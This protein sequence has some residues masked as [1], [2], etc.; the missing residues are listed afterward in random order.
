M[1]K[2][3]ITLEFFLTFS[4]FLVLVILFSYSILS[5]KNTIDRSKDILQYSYS[6]EADSRAVENSLYSGF[7]MNYSFDEGVSYRIENGVMHYKIGQRVIEINGIFS[8]N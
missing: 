6:S 7:D 1:A 3:Q 8:S 2:G 4:I 5:T